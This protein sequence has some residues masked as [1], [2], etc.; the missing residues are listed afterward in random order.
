MDKD[1][2]ELLETVRSAKDPTMAMIIAIGIIRDFLQQP[3]PL[4]QQEDDS[5]L[6]QGGKI[7]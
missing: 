7:E 4:K 3:L 5:L 1:E 6:E 2:N